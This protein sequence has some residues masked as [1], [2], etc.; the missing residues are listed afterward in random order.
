MIYTSGSTGKPKGAM[1]SHRAI[2]NRLLWM[3]D[4][5]QLDETDRV[6]QKTPF[7][8][9]V[10]VWEFFWPLL[11]GAGLV[12]AQPGGHR[13]AAYLVQVIAAERITTVHF[14]PSMLQLFLA[15]PELHRLDSLKRVICSG[16]EL[17]AELA[18]RCLA[19]LPEV[20]LE[21]LYG[22][23]E[24]SVDVSWWSCQPGMGDRPVPIG[25][26]IQNCQLY[27]LDAALHPVPVGV[28]G[29]LFIGGVGLARG[30]LHRPNLTAASFVPSPFHID[31]DAGGERLYRTGDLARWLPDGS[32]EYLGRRDHQLKIR[33]F[34]VELVGI[35]DNFFE[36][37]GTS[38]MAA[39]LVNWL[40][41]AFGVELPVRRLF[42]GPTVAELAVAINQAEHQDKLEA[43][44]SPLV[45]IQPRGSRLPFFCVAP[46]GGQVFCYFPLAEQLGLQQ[47]F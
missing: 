47:P 20:Q 30:Y 14:V 44:W 19:R 25:R 36:L 4:A 32:L 29:E 40:R 34:R 46:V 8:F 18:E 3:Q 2:C 22:P 37:G 33:G 17:P 24:A 9:D 42:Q 6:L 45:E 10:S 26:P 15:E 5:Y 21:N 1:N 27:V 28:S 11:T 7:S 35:H 31:K 16:E 12:M 23:T 38:L 43:P 41:E 39:H 13:D